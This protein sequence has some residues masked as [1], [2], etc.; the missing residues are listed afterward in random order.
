MDL[1]D[2]SLAAMMADEAAREFSSRLHISPEEI[3]RLKLYLAFS[4]KKNGLSREGRLR[5]DNEFR[6]LMLASEIIRMAFKFVTKGGVEDDKG[7]LF[8][9]YRMIK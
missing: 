6:C 1:P 3:H 4:L 5:L 2:F 8:P 7:D 9:R